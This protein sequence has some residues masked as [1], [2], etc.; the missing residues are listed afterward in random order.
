MKFRKPTELDAKIGMRVRQLRMAADISQSALAKEIGISVQ[1]MTKYE[2][3][4]DRILTGRLWT[5]AEVFDVSIEDLFRYCPANLQKISQ[6]TDHSP[7]L[8]DTIFGNKMSLS[9]SRIED[10]AIRES[11][12]KYV[13]SKAS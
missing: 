12:L 13:Q 7:I 3:G 2:R 5:I 4:Q 6:T 8:S 10:P 1:Q 11:I 9:L